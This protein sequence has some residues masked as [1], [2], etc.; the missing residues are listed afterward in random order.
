MTKNYTNKSREQALFVFYVC[1][2]F[3]FRIL[4]CLLIQDGIVHGERWCGNTHNVE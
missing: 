4:L 3:A 1:N 2:C